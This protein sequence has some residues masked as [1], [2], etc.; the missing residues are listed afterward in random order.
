MIAV[1]A[2]AGAALASPAYAFAPEDS[3]GSD[4]PGQQHAIYGGGCEKQ[5]TGKQDVNPNAHQGYGGEYNFPS[6]CDHFFNPQN[7]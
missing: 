3:P 2:A 6:N 7:R 1:T 4:A 5:L